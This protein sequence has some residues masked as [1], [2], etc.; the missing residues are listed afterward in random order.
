MPGDKVRK[1]VGERSKF[2]QWRKLQECVDE[3][4]TLCFVKQHHNKTGWN[5]LSASV[6][7]LVNHLLTVNAQDWPIE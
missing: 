3:P 6:K 2:I 4:V 1:Q 5:Q 7:R